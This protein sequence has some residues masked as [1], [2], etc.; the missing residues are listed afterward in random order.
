MK[1]FYFAYSVRQPKLPK[2]TPAD[3]DVAEHVILGNWAGVQRVSEADNLPCV[4]SRLQGLTAANLCTSKRA[5]EDVA[6]LW[7]DSYKANGTY[8]FA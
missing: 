8:L 4:L 6:R 7:N 2:F 5:A 3:S 1:Y